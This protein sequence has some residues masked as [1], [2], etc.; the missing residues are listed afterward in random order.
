MAGDLNERDRKGLLASTIHEVSRRRHKLFVDVHCGAVADHLLES[1]LFGHERGAFTGAV[2]DKPGLLE[3]ADG[4]TL[5][6]DEFAEM[7]PEMQTKLLKVLDSGE[8]RR[9]GG[10]RTI[11]VDVRVLV[12]T[13]RDL[14]GL[15]HAGRLREDLL[16]RVDVIRRRVRHL[17]DCGAARRVFSERVSG[18]PDRPGSGP[19]PRR[20]RCLIHLVPSQASRHGGC[21][22]EP[23]AAYLSESYGKG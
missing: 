14:D 2:S 4:G 22:T 18:L 9:V 16:H 7:T 23:R 15:V 12:A 10:V 13:N 17:V 19:Y 5:F 11:T 21:L 1:E 8:L 20:Y 3:I 6:L